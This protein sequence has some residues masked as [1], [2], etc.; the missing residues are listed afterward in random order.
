MGL[1][2]MGS[3]SLGMAFV[4]GRKRVPK[5][6]A[7]ITALRTL[8]LLI[9]RFYHARCGRLAGSFA[10]SILRIMGETIHTPP[11]IIEPA[12]LWTKYNLWS[13]IGISA[14]RYL[15][16]CEGAYQ[17]YDPEMPA[18]NFDHA[19]ETADLVMM[20]ADRY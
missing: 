1:S 20:L 11:E 7:A 10:G 13:T 14:G 18:H 8:F 16:L 4:C 3:I 9:T 15:Q 19:L 12:L 17:N 2:T 6:A 5:P